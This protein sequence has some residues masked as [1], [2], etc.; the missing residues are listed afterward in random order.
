MTDAHNARMRRKYKRRWNNHNNAVTRIAKKTMR[1][2]TT[3]SEVN[4]ADWQ[5]EIPT[6][7]NTN[8]EHDRF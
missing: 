7:E 8:D 1:D 5:R 2:R 6:E 3:E 4:P